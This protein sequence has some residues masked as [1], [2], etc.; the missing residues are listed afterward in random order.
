MQG[1]VWVA[2]CS[3]SFPWLSSCPSYDPSPAT[4]RHSTHQEKVVPKLNGVQS[5]TVFILHES[6]QLEWDPGG[7]HP[8]CLTT[9][10]VSH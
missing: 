10:L 7:D 8:Q 3:P 9:W 1:S 5:F 4:D 6:L 2:S